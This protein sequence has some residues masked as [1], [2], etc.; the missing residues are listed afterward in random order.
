MSNDKD[1]YKVLGVN[2]ASSPKEIK[3]AYVKLSKKYAPVCYL[4]DRIPM[5]TPKSLHSRRP[6]QISLDPILSR[7]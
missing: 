3:R 6:K 4:W 1:Y 7:R 2:Y 5:I